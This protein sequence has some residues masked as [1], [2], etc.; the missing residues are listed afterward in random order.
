MLKKFLGLTVPFVITGVLVF[1][2]SPSTAD[3]KEKGDAILRA[4]MQ[5][6]AV[7]H[8][9]PLPINDEFSERVFSLYIEDLD[10]AKRFLLQPDVDRL[11]Q[12]KTKIDNQI[13]DVNYD[14]F[15]LSVNIINER[16]TEAKAYYTEILANPFNFDKDETIELDAKKLGYP[17]DKDEMKQRWYESLKYQTMTRLSDML[18]EQEKAEAK[19]NTD[20]VS[21]SFADMEAEARQ[22]VL[23]NQDTWFNR[24]AKFTNEDRMSV[25][26]NAITSAYDPHSNYFPPKAKEDF[27]ISLSGRLEGI[28]ATLQEKDGYIRVI[29]IVPGSPSAIQGELQV[30]DIITKVAQGTDEPVDVVD[31]RLDDA[32]QLIRGKKGTE[33]RLTIKKVDG[34]TK[35]IPIIRDIVMIEEGYAKSAIVKDT[36]LATTTGYIN[37]PKFYA[38]FN[39]QDGRNCA[40]DVLKEIKKL[41]VEG[42]NGIILDLR[43]NGGGSLRDVVDMAGLFINEGPIVQVKSRDETPYLYNDRDPNVQYEGPLVILV[44]QFS[45]S[46]SEI[47]AAAMQDYGRAIIV[48][49]NATY[50]KGTVQRFTNLDALVADNNLR[51]LGSLKLTIQKFYR[52]NGHTTQLNGVIPDI[53]LPDKYAYIDVGEKEQDYAMPFD[54]ISAASY[55]PWSSANKFDLNKIKNQSQERVSHNPTFQLIDEQAN[56]LKKQRNETTETLNLQKYIAEKKQI[57]GDTKKF[58]AI[59]GEIPQLYIQSMQADISE[60]AGDTA[61]LARAKDFTNKLQKDVYLLEAISIINDMNTR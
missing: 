54:Q 16:I 39:H 55:K 14:F 20:Y 32:V 7:E 8:Y 13:R 19:G 28:G 27:D 12:Y 57:S 18:E 45:A 46:A 53:I 22:K 50:G 58:E 61:K 17:K 4:I 33:V 6:L 35:V 36:E 52:I 25:Y 9:N 29:S 11:A 21:K 40:E 10:A 5:D 26:L 24:M 34:S 15:N 1:G 60:M 48:G 51:P 23:K 37:L 43:D 31:M 2:F 47:M 42:I 38:D 30:D 3:N 44:N 56:Y 49:S 41:K 59:T